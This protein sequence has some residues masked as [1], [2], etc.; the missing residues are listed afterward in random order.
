MPEDYP[1]CP[2]CLG[3]TGLCLSC[4]RKILPQLAIN[5]GWLKLMGD[6]H[7]EQT[8]RQSRRLDS[9]QRAAVAKAERRKVR[10]A[11]RL[12]TITTAVRAA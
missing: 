10:K 7:I 9:S 6:A 12:A 3:R 1:E 5:I 2:D 11:R 8:K 4:Q